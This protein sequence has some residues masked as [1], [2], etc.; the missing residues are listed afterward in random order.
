MVTFIIDGYKPQDQK[1]IATV[2]PFNTA[3]PE[4]CLVDLLVR[5]GQGHFGSLTAG[6]PLPS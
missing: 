1:T 2:P 5:E 4:K 6:Y 3:N